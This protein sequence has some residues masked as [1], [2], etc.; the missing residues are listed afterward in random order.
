MKLRADQLK[1]HLSKGIFQ[2]LYIVSG[3]EP[4]LLQET[5]D[6]LR[7]AIR[8][9]GFTERECFT[10]ETGFNWNQ[11]LQSS[12]NMSLFGDRKLIELRLPKAKVDE[13]GKKT[14]AAYIETPSPDNILM[15]MLP[16]LDRKTLST[17]WFQHLE[18][19]GALI[20]IWPITDQQ[21]PKWIQ[22]RMNLVGLQPNADAVELL[23]ERVEGNLLA[24]AQEVEKLA[25]LIKPGPVNGP[26]IQAAVADHAQYT[27][28]ELVDEAIQ[29]NHTQ[30]LKI[31]NFIKASG[32]EPVS[33]L[34]S[35]A[36]DLRALEGIAAQ[37][38]KGMNMS[39]AFRDFGVWDN[40]KSLFQK[41]LQKHNSALFKTALQEAANIDHAIKGLAK[42]DPWIGFSNII[43]LLSGALKPGTLTI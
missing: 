30:A 29:G 12:Q 20:Q 23:C 31:L 4:L 35:F 42:G 13:T 27:Q 33:L 38:E 15:L 10:V 16:K 21:L 22:Q 40:R 36:K 41:A 7:Q 43:L 5:C 39:K 3:D 19:Q 14:L 25:L 11:L 24:A 2:P 18:Q 34:W 9:A 6:T 26:T 28:F 8:A 17:K 1:Q 37:R 32:T